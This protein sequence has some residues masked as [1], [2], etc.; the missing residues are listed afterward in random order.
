MLLTSRHPL[1]QMM[2]ASS[3]AASSTSPLNS[4]CEGA[5][6]GGD[7]RFCSAPGPW[8]TA[9]RHKKPGNPANTVFLEPWMTNP[10]LFGSTRRSWSTCHPSNAPTSTWSVHTLQPPRDKIRRLVHVLCIIQMR[11]PNQVPSSANVIRV[12]T[13]DQ[14]FRRGNARHQRRIVWVAEDH[15]RA[16]SGKN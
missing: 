12:V 5:K 3:T 11:G 8:N 15:R 14:L 1:S 4:S 13:N 16:D 10:P 9:G 7:C 2:Q 6:K